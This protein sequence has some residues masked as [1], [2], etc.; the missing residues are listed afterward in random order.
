MTTLQWKFNENSYDFTGAPSNS[1]KYINTNSN[2]AETD[3]NFLNV[4]HSSN[5]VYVDLNSEHNANSSYTIDFTVKDL[6][7][8]TSNVNYLTFGYH[9][10]GH[11]TGSITVGKSN[12]K[13]ALGVITNDSTVKAS[14]STSSNIFANEFVKLRLIHDVT[15]Y[16]ED[17]LRLYRVIDESTSELV[18]NASNLP[19]FD[20]S[21]PDAKLI[22]GTSGWVNETG[23]NNTFDVANV[24]FSNIEMTMNNTMFP[25]GSGFEPSV[26]HM[27]YFSSISP[28]VLLTKFNNTL[29]TFYVKIQMTNYYDNITIQ[30][31]LK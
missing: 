8:S 17:K 24:V 3:T 22:L 14:P 30:F 6:D 16:N 25:K 18:C 1:F 15:E 5:L 13:Y 21:I 9:T 31:Y 4:S 10:R 11:D 26:T 23:Y 2:V 29:Q 20:Y 12:N 7:D 19:H 28:D 27:G